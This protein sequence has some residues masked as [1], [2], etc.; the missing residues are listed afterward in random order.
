MRRCRSIRLARRSNKQRVL[1]LRV[2]AR[3]HVHIRTYTDAM[4]IRERSTE[5]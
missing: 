1:H 2:R 4:R 3:A 5:E